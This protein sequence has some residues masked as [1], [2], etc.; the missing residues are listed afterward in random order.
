MQRLQSVLAGVTTRAVDHLAVIRGLAFRVVPMAAL[1]GVGDDR[2]S[3][4]RGPLRPIGTSSRTWRRAF[5]KGWSA[6]PDDVV[7]EPT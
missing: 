1:R 4:H 5:A 3:N 2:F 7:W 6:L